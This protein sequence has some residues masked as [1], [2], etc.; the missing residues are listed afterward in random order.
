MFAQ[1]FRFALNLMLTRLLAPDLFG[2]MAIAN[3]AMIGIAMISDVGLGPNIIRSPRGRNSDFLNTAWTIQVLRGFLTWI[4]G[5][6]VASAI[7]LAGRSDLAPLGS[8]YSDPRLPTV[9]AAISV[10]ALIAGFTSTKVHEARRSLHVARLTLNEINAQLI[11]VACIIGWLWFD[12]SVWAL[13]A[14]AISNS[15][16]ATCLSHINLP[17]TSNRFRWDSA[18]ASEIFKFGA[19][20]FV[21]S[22]LTF[23]AANSDRL[24]L[25][26]LMNSSLLG[27]YSIAF[28]LFSAIEQLASR[29]IGMVSLPAISETVRDRPAHLSTIHYR[30]HRIIAGAMYFAAGT[31]F[32]AGH[33]LVRFFYDARYDDAGWM[34]QILSLALISVPSQVTHQTFIAK[35]EPKLASMVLVGRLVILFPAVLG[36]F[37]LFG[38]RGALGGLV[39]SFLSAIPAT[40]IIS[41]RLGI[42]QM[43]N[44]LLPLPTFF[45]GLGVGYAV[46]VALNLVD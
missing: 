29:M 5:L 13:V 28:G 22:L 18:A 11:S 45:V 31:L 8:V 39:I 20:I 14:G 23:A 32:T 46:A 6:L 35:G 10:T 41:M 7:L 15:A 25:G 36:G 3:V 43:K 30:F 33:A 34:L 21:S 17:G 37:S 1:G 9:V 44:E 12:R 2:L 24:L 38:V 26:A 19:W 40:A 42:F 27:I 16:A 4:I